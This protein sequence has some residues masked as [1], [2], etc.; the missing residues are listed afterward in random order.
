ME[1]YLGQQDS[2]RSKRFVQKLDRRGLE[3]I[4]LK[5]SDSSIHGSGGLDQEGYE[6]VVTF[7]DWFLHFESLINLF[8]AVPS[9]MK[10]QVIANKSTALGDY[11]YSS[12]YRHR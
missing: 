9:I 1:L 6:P 8:L 2:G 7:L 4:T 10:S 11:L 12:P 5:R 3:R